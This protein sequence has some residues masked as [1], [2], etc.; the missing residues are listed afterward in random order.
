MKTILSF[1]MLGASA[2]GQQPP[3]PA[4]APT[5]L[6]QVK[7]ENAALRKYIADY[8]VWVEKIYNAEVA[9]K[10]S[11]LGQAPKVPPA[12]PAAPATPEKGKQ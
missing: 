6:E 11:C 5:E 4:P 2:F 10:A 12:P 3:A 8:E 1:L 7:T 9:A